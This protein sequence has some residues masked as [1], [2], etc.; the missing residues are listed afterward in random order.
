MRLID[1]DKIINI[2][3]DRATNE[4]VCGYMTAYD[5]TKSIIG[6][7]DE[8]PVA[9]DVDKAIKQLEDMESLYQRLRELKDKDYLKYGYKIET[10]IDAIKIVKAG[11]KV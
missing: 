9:Y 10:L 4:A 2:L 3:K 11:E 8:Q 6:E 5:V 1:A 7:I